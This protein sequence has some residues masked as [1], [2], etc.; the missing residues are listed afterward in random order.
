[1]ITAMLQRQFI[2]DSDGKQIGVILPLEELK[3]LEDALESKCQEEARQLEQMKQAAN[4][5][6]F[7]EDL[8]ETMNAFSSI[9]SEGWEDKE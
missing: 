1:M 7:M 6:L 2:T 3:T 8:K 9:D 4:D 5:P